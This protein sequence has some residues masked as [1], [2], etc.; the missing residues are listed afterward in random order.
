MSNWQLLSFFLQLVTT[1]ERFL[2]DSLY[3]EGILIVWDPSVYHSDIPKVSEYPSE[4]EVKSSIC[5]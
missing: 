5:L 2:K 1:E 3:N 4:I